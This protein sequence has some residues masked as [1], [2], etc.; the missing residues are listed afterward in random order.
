MFSITVHESIIFC[1]FGIICNAI[2]NHEHRSITHVRFLKRLL[3][4]SNL[5]ALY[6]LLLTTTVYAKMY[7][8][9]KSEKSDWSKWFSFFLFCIAFSM[10][11]YFS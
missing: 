9:K 1:Q 4:Q 3:L 5:L 6:L 7:V 2:R 10:S 8:S 11:E